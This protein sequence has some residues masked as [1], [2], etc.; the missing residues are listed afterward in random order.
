MFVVHEDLAANL[1]DTLKGV[2][3]TSQ[4]LSSVLGAKI[5]SCKEPW[6]SYLTFLCRFVLIS[7]LV[8]EKAAKTSI[9]HPLGTTN[10]NAI[11]LL[12]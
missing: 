3:V 5:C 9:S 2:N 12:L 10:L 1:V 7:P 6:D 8:W 11:T 4:Q